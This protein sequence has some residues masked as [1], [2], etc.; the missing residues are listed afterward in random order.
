MNVK[1][2]F[3]IRVYARAIRPTGRTTIIINNTTRVKRI[4]IYRR[5][6][7][8]YY[9]LRTFIPVRRFAVVQVERKTE[10]KK[11]QR[12]VIK[13]ARIVFIGGKTRRPSATGTRCATRAR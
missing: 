5:R 13:T 3:N 2:A 8:R 10:R 7:R 11:Q 12:N 6:C 1:R 9:F 4:C